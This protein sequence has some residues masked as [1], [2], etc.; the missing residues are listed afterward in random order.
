MLCITNNSIKHQSFVYTQLNDQTVLYLKIQFRISL[1]F[2]LSLNVKQFYLILSGAPTPSQGRS[3]S[4]AMKGALQIPQNSSITGVSPP[5]CLESYPGRL[6]GLNP[7]QRCS[8]CILQPQLTG[9][10][11]VCVDLLYNVISLYSFGFYFLDY[12]LFPFS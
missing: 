5:N 2:A 9:L 7:L 10:G 6:W 3:G 8:W 11:R 1:L 4:N 12:V